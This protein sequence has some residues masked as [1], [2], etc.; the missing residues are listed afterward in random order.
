MAPLE[1]AT[2]PWE[3]SRGLLRR[4][5]LDGAILL[6]PAFVVHTIGMRFPIDVAFC[7]RNLQVLATVTMGP[8]RLSRP[9][10]WARSVLEASAG[11]FAGWQL[12]RGSQLAI[13]HD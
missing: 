8:N 4:D 11:A 2:L 3:L 12:E 13:E 10:V 5:G 7:D 6:T 9:R 1:T